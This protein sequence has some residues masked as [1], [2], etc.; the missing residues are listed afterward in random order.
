R[1]DQQ[2]SFRSGSTQ[3]RVFLRVLEKIHDLDELVFGLI[4][5]GNVIKTDL[6][7]P[8][9]VIPASFTSTNSHE[10]AHATALLSG[11]TKHPSI[12]TDEQQRGPKSK[13]ESRP[14]V[15]AFLD[16]LSADL[17]FVFD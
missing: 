14:R 5:A 3:T 15:A 8:F 9:Q 10:P 13:N 2:H 7:I 17:H 12:K 16:R 4:N 1:A 11:A 6:H